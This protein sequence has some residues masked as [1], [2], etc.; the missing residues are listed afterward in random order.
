MFAQCTDGHL[1]CSGCRELVQVLCLDHCYHCQFHQLHYC[2]HHLYLLHEKLK[3][4]SNG[5]MTTAWVH[6]FCI[7]TSDI[8]VI[9]G[10]KDH[11]ETKKRESVPKIK[12]K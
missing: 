6:S 7:D 11:I 10:F 2:H 1:L 12:S 4:G 3:H 8:K 5:M 9:L